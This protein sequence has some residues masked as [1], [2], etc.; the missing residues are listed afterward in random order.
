MVNDKNNIKQRNVNTVFANISKTIWLTSDS[1][2]LIMSHVAF[3]NELTPL[4]TT[5]T[6][7]SAY[8]TSYCNEPALPTSNAIFI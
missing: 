5:C 7:N 2:P 6:D 3:W 1:F 8:E 4:F